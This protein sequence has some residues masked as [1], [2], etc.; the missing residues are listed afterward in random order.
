MDSLG[1]RVVALVCASIIALVASGRASAFTRHDLMLHMDDGVDLGATLYEPS[2]DP[3]PQGFPTIV[4]FHGIGGAR[5]DLDFV[6]QKWAD[7]F[8]V[9]S[10]D[11][12]GHGQSGGLVS[13]DGPREIADTRAVHGWLAARPEIDPHAIGAWGISLGGGAILRSLVQPVPIPWAAVETVQTWSDLYVA[14]APQK[15]SK[16]GAIYGLLSS[17]PESRRDP[18]LQAIEQNAIASRNL[19][20][21]HAWAD[22]RSSRGRLSLVRTPVYLFQGRRDFVFD[23]TE[24]TAAYDLLKGA[25]RLY[26]GDF[27]HS[28]STFPGPDIARVLTEGEAWFSRWLIRSSMPPVR[29]PIT[30]AA[31]PWAGKAHRFKKLPR[32]RDLK[33]AFPGRATFPARGKA[34]RTSGRLRA[35]LETFGPARVRVKL[36]LSGGWSRVVA[37]VT[38]K[39]RRGKTIVVSEGGFNTSGL[40]G[41]C[42]LTI[43]MIDDATLIPRGATLTLTLASSSLAQDPSNLLFLDLPMPPAATISVGPAQLILPV[44]RKPISR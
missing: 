26:I 32:T 33:V 11:A 2:G 23:L 5:Q 22:Q 25:K 44:L 29:Y 18:T 7:T 43:R 3:P 1:R 9:L 21:L 27:G 10:F 38:A 4:L 28:P 17:V 39:P 41:P 42:T 15:L 20:A 35:R 30:I 24:A 19:E 16:S 31:D 12:R 8:A 36:R 37:V 13:V 34:Q 14:L 40:R 6:A